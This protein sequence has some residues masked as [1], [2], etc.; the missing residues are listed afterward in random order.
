MLS[1]SKS[2]KLFPSCA[3]KTAIIP[4]KPMMKK[5]LYS[6]IIFLGFLFQAAHLQ[7]QNS[8]RTCGS[9]HYLEQQNLQYPELRVERARMQQEI[10]RMAE[11]V[12]RTSNKGTATIYTIPV[13]VH[14]VYNTT[15]QNISDSQIYTQI[16]ALNRDYQL[17]NADTSLIP[18]AFKSLKADMQ[19]QFCLAQRDPNGAA[20]TGITRTNTSVTSFIDDDKMK[21]PAT[22]GIAPWPRN[23]YLNLWVCNM[24]SLL[25]YAQFPGGPAST[26]GVVIHYTA[27]GTTGLLQPAYNQGRTATHE[28]G[29]WLG[30]LHTFEG[31]CTGNGDFVADTP[32]QQVENYGCPAFPHMSCSGTANGDMFM[33]FMDYVNDAC[34]QM[35][36]AGQKA[37]AIL[38]LTNIPSMDSIAT[39]SQACVPVAPVNNEAGTATI[40]TPGAGCTGAIY[41]NVNATQSAGEV[42][43]SCCEAAG[44]H[45][46]W[47]RFNAPASGAVRIS[48]D[49]GSGNTLTDTHLALFSASNASNYNTFQSISCDDNGGSAV[50]NNLSV[51][52]ATGLTSG[53]TYY[54]AVD[55]YNGAT[56]TFCIR[57]D[58]MDETMIS[59]ADCSSTYQ[60]PSGSTSY[61]GWVPLM[62]NNS[63][64]VA[65]VQNP[66]GGRVSSYTAAQYINTGN[67]RSGLGGRYYLDRNY[68]INNPVATNVNVRLFFPATALTAISTVSPGTLLGNLGISRQS[69]SLCSGDYDLINGITSSLS[70]TASGNVSNVN[71]VEF[72]TPGFSNFFV[73]GGLSTPLPVTIDR[74]SVNNEGNHNLL[75]WTTRSETPGMMY[76]LERSRNGKDFSQLAVINGN[77]KSSGYAYTDKFPVD[78]V[79]FYRLHILESNGDKYYSN[80]IS[81]H[82]RTNNLVNIQTIPNPVTDVLSVNISGPV[83]EHASIRLMDITGQI[84]I[85]KTANNQVTFEMQRLPSGI[86]ILQYID[87][88]SRQVIRINKQ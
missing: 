34:M 87:G 45:T 28:V 38:Y 77:S 16:A 60:T 39:K 61:T 64:L 83:P 59:S 84:L 55:G 10:G 25:G 35:F 73:T 33:N 29:H 19:I 49:A 23:K 22:G 41:S 68:M 47:F 65:M 46:V 15:G 66:A 75:E 70:Q 3:G 81:V 8:N 6:L 32:P 58:A 9:M 37:R 2:I 44:T 63:K 42:F 54:I 78:G 7:A 52:Y 71:W 5:L 69:Y 30:L 13:V 50:G 4:T 20:T 67:V 72:T 56:G 48:T 79:N 74:F 17:K 85:S 1:L 26:D 11:N 14:V 51:L 53:Q 57:V 86:Y 18:G 31:G 43:P 27:F 76:A 24:P 40:L 88:N 82:T 12:G 36:S 62:D 21:S 80:I